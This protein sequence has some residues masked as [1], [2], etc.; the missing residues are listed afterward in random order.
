VTFV[1]FS[2]TAAT[3]KVGVFIVV[4]EPASNFAELA[5]LMNLARL[6][7]ANVLLQ[8]FIVVLWNK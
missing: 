6:V 8:T 2:I 1:F 3:T 5:L 4:I 7:H